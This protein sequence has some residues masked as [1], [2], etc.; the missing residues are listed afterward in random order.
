MAFDPQVEL[1]LR[2]LEDSMWRAETRYDRAYMDSVLHADFTE[3]GRSGRVFS[4]DD[5]L[6]MP[7][8]DIAFAISHEGFS[9]ARVADGIALITYAT[10]PTDARYGAAHRSSLWVAEDDR[11]LLRFHQGTPFA[12]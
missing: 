5:V 7:H 11:W 4:R 6:D 1:N 9:L 10:V 8:G 3:I 12:Q 2:A